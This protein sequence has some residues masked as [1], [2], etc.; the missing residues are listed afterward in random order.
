MLTPMCTRHQAHTIICVIFFCFLFLVEGILFIIVHY[1]YSYFTLSF[2][3]SQ[4][5]LLPYVHK[6]LHSKYVYKYKTWCWLQGS[7]WSC[8]F[9]V[10]KICSNLSL[11]A[12][13]GTIY[14]QYQRI[15]NLELLQHNRLKVCLDVHSKC[16]AG[17]PR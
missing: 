7:R 10:Y 14:F 9:L 17:I 13:Q 2:F 1:R 16:G 8:S 6:L 15:F 12:S 5:L 3:S 11:L 4:V